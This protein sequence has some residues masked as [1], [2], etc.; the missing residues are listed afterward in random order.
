MSKWVRSVDGQTWL[1]LDRLDVIGVM[2]SSPQGD[3]AL[4]IA[5][6]TGAPNVILSKHPHKASALLR[7]RQLIGDDSVEG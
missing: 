7:L 5:E 6:R 3:G 1:N 2:A 4:L